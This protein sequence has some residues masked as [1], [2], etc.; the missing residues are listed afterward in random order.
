MDT[1]SS[2]EII[3]ELGQRFAQH[4]KRAKLTQKD[5]AEQS[6]VSVFTISGFENG[7]QSGITLKTFIK[8][9]RAIGEEEAMQNILLEQPPSPKE[10]FHRIHGKKK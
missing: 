8:L 10:L 2:I 3:H 7:S 9:L 5:V 1:P 4:R 6:G